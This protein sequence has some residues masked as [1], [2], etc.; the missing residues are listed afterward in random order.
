MS[1]AVVAIAERIFWRDAFG[2]LT[3]RLCCASLLRMRSLSKCCQL[4]VSLRSAQVWRVASLHIRPVG[5]AKKA[6]RNEERERQ[7]G[8]VKETELCSALIN[9]DAA[10][11]MY[12]IFGRGH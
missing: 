10:L 12:P 7:L 2:I 6:T 8:E 4:C 5:S 1:A 11:T 9:I 3:C